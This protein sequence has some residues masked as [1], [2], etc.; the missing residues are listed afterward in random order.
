MTNHAC[1]PFIRLISRFFESISSSRSIV[2]METQMPVLLKVERT[3]ALVSPI[4][5][6]RPL[7]MANRLLAPLRV[8]AIMLITKTSV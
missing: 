2:E 7:I 8:N 1:G 6:N 3:R 5:K 4:S